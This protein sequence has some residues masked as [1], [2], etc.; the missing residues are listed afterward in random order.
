ML[1]P[2]RAT[3][4]V[5]AEA[6]ADAENLAGGG[7]EKAPRLPKAATGPTKCSSP[8]SPSSSSEIS[9]AVAE[10]ADERRLRV[11]LAAAVATAAATERIAWCGLWLWAS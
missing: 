10:G 2:P 6:G 3:G 1:V 5:A 8:E 7:G 11:P 4:D 9:M